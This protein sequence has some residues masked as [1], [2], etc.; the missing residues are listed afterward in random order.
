MSNMPTGG[1][2][3]KGVF[4]RTKEMWQRQIIADLKLTSGTKL[5]GIAIS[6]H[7][8]RNSRLA[9]PGINTLARLTSTSRDT[10][11]RAIKQ[12]EKGGHVGVDRSRV[13]GK[14]A[15]NRYRPVLKCTQGRCTE[16]RCTHAPRTSE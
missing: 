11:K 3:G 6:W 13:A 5:V 9:W 16:G 1:S 12:L 2:E 14:N 15:A 10:V 8:N 7:L 4:E